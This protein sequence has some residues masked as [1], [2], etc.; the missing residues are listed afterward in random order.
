[1]AKKDDS[2]P[3]FERVTPPNVLKLKA[4]GGGMDRS[5]QRMVQA[6]AALKNLALEHDNWLDTTLRRL[7][8][9]RADF[10]GNANSPHIRDRFIR[11]SLDVKGLG[12]T[13]G[14]PLLTRVA[15]SLVRMLD[16]PGAVNQ[17]PAE[18]IDR[19]IV[20][21][22]SIVGGRWRNTAPPVFLEVVSE[23]ERGVAELRARG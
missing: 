16:F 15:A 8:T 14:Y 22:R 7:E 2:D 10:A 11:A 23:L 4:A 5:R 9:A 20:A 13:I 17:P 19:H 21:L 3:P 1:M 12:S 18:L 6:E